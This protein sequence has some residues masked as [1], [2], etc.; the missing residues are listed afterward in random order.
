MTVECI[1]PYYVCVITWDPIGVWWCLYMCMFDP[2]CTCERSCRCLTVWDTTGLFARVCGPTGVSVCVCPCKCET[3]CVPTCVGGCI[4]A[5]MCEWLCVWPRG[6]R[7]WLWPYMCECLCVFLQGWVV[8]CDTIGV[9][10][11]V[12]PYN[13]MCVWRGVYARLRVY[14]AL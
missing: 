12:G 4:W 5:C 2:T 7:D 8:V 14:E 1:G 6:V 3:V 13:C 9:D 11:C 10:G